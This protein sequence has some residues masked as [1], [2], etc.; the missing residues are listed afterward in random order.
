[1]NQKENKQP[2]FKSGKSLPAVTDYDPPKPA[3][4]KGKAQQMFEDLDY[5]D[6]FEESGQNDE[7]S[8]NANELMKLN[9][10]APDNL[11]IK[12]VLSGNAAKKVNNKRYDGEFEADEDWGDDWGSQKSDKLDNFD[13]KNQNLNKLDDRTLAKHKANM[14]KGFEKNQLKPGDDGFEY[15]KRV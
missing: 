3:N 14:E 2:T 4:L 8:F 10:K 11:N 12:D 7:T 5:N 1:M 9:K 6:D 13:Y 15:D